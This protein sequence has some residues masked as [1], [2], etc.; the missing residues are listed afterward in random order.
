MLL[1]QY[2]TRVWGGIAIATVLGLSLSASSAHAEDD[3][4]D[5]GKSFTRIATFPVYLNNADIAD[6][7][8]AEIIDATP[9]GK[10]LVYTDAETEAVGFI[11]I[12]KPSRPMPLGT[13]ALSG[14]PTS[15]SVRGNYA[16]VGINTSPSLVAPSGELVII[17]IRQQTI[18][19][20]LPLAGQPDSLKV[21]PNR[22]YCAIV[23]EN[24]R[25]EDIIVNGVEGGLPQ[26]PAGL[27]QILDMRGN[28]NTWGLRS[29]SLTGLAGLEPSDPEP[30]FV[31]INAKNQAVI[32]LQENNAAVVVDLKTGTVV[33]AFGLGTVDLT[34]VDLTEERDISLT[35]SQPN[36]PREPDS[37]AWISNNMFATANEGDFLGGSRGFSIFN[38]SGH[39]VFESGSID[40]VAVRHGHYPD[41]R[42]GNKGNEPE[43]IAFGKFGGKKLLFVGSE[44][45][46]FVAVYGVD[47]PHQPHFKQFIPTGLGPEG[48]LPIPSRNL[49]VVSTE[50]DDPSFG[51]RATV[52]IYKYNRRP[53]GYPQILSDDDNSDRPIAW[54]ALSGMSA[55]PGVHD[56][57]IA[58][59]DSFY[60]QSRAF[61]IDVDHK[62]AIVRHAIDITGGTGNYD[63]EGI[64]FAPDG[65][66]WI[67]SEGNGS[68]TRKNRLLQTTKSGSVLAEVGLPADIEAC[69][70]ASS[71]T[72][73]LGAGF[74]GVAAVPSDGCGSGYML[75]VAQQRG[76]DYTTAA[77]E[78]LDDDPTGANAGEPGQTRIW[79]YCPASGNWDAISYEL[80][81]VPANASWVGLSEI[82]LLPDGTLM[83]IERDNR[84]GDFTSIKNLVRI[85]LARDG[86]GGIT[87][88]EKQRYDIIRPLKA[89]NGWITDKPEG[90]AV[91]PNGRVF[92]V[93]D[94]DGVD[95]WSGETWFLR[96]G[97]YRRL[98][99][100]H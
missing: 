41:E 72:G 69:R 63:P 31:D 47:N 20:T 24:E 62:P 51:V 92:L 89:T 10:T 87:R 67:A 36:V 56:Q 5:Y 81:P 34:D 93:T 76:W 23:I 11:D 59:W 88:A 94:N 78:A 98:F 100:R 53:A 32:S 28:V 6:E 21:S 19:R 25:D 90:T 77:C 4:D 43:A 84:T 2:L 97:K 96:L 52:S 35:E 15:V 54:S 45:G 44:R 29:V 65:T 12:R 27:L 38:K 80:D 57:V 7:T 1:D 68:G 58:V 79:K 85:D 66:M 30:E 26:A 39:L 9:N 3:Y 18:V 99:G 61:I 16:L 60:S 13:V 49:L 70:A 73:S 33:S 95:D 86:A 64:T 37:V 42:S 83:L 50:V 71:N 40:D 91:L 22:R 82:T 14:E 55:I 17:D 75:L 74:E 48:V 46:N 8:V